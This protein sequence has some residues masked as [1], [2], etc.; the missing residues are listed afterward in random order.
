MA[1]NACDA[2]ISRYYSDE[3][4]SIDDQTII[5]RCFYLNTINNNYENNNDLLR[6]TSLTHMYSKIKEFL[7]RD[8]SKSNL[9]LV[10]FSGHDTNI[11]QVLMSLF[12]GDDECILKSMMVSIIIKYKMKIWSVEDCKNILLMLL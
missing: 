10:L 11:S 5:D 2:L 8:L 4:F 9:K 6:K 1:T 7:N 12:P 3:N